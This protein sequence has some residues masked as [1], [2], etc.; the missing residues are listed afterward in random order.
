[1]TALAEG[2][3]STH[4]MF[5]AYVTAGFTRAEALQIVIAIVTSF[6]PPPQPPKES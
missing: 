5:M 2:A 4:E 1:M 6:I 3:T